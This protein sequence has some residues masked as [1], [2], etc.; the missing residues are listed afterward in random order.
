[1]TKELRVFGLTED[2]L[3]H[4]LA[5]L[6]ADPV[7]EVTLSVFEGD[8]TV[9]LSAPEEVLP[10]LCEEVNLRLNGYV[11]SETGES[12]AACVVRLLTAHGLTVATAES[13]TGGLIAAA[14]TDVPGASQV[15]G[16]GVVS[17]SNRCKQELLYVSPDTL[18]AQGAV[19]AATAGQMARGVRQTGA[20]DLGVSVTGEAGPQPAEQHPVGTVFIALADKKRTWVE[21]LH[22]EGA[23]RASI[24]RQATQ[25]VLWL[26]WRYLSAHPARMAGGETHAAALRREIPRAKG[27]KHPPLLSRLLPWRGDSRRRILIKCAVWLVTLAVLASFAYVGYLFLSEGQRNRELQSSLGELYWESVDLTEGVDDPKYP[28]GMLPAFRGLYDLNPDVGGWLY[29]PGSGMDY[30]VMKYADGYYRNHNFMKEYST[31][32]QPYFGASG[33]DRVV[34]VYGQNPGDGQMFSDLTNYRRLAY[35]QG[36]DTI[37]CNFTTAN[38]NWQ[39]FAVLV[40]DEDSLGQFRYLPQ[41]EFAGDEAYLAYIDSLR[42][43]SLFTS[44][45]SVGA[46][47][48]ILLLTTEAEEEYEHDGARL[49]VAARQTD[50]TVAEVVYENNPQVRLPAFLAGTTRWHP[51]TTTS[52]STTAGEGS[53]TA[54]QGSATDGSTTATGSGSDGS[55]TATQSGSETED[56]TTATGSD[57][58]SGSASKTQSATDTATGTATGTTP[59]TQSTNGTGTATGTTPTTESTSDT[60]APTESNGTTGT[61]ADSATSSTNGVGTTGEGTTQT[62]ASDRPTEPT[63]EAE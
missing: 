48:T 6:M 21:E 26:L 7:M 37:E 23:D 36:H 53:T 9:T 12:L 52:T 10:E 1:M 41:E 45:L 24:R 31:Y 15:I 29:V 49:V 25:W 35:L 51:I 20:A 14:L 63:K 42:Q 54:T 3:A 4:R 28:K 40:V 22:L 47:D 33:S 43:R 34:C 57:N 18:T 44:T 32:G 56:A 61:D 58:T 17:Y 11:Y 16:T 5:D 38:H 59:T 19:S 27:A 2:A 50:G 39:I 30:P 46:E 60:T 13:C 55:T 62:E 8:A